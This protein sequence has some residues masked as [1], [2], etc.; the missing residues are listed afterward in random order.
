MRSQQDKVCE[1][2][3]LPVEVVADSQYLRSITGETVQ[4]YYYTVGGVLTVD[5]GQAAGTVVVGKT[6]YGGILTNIG[7]VIGTYLD[8]S[9][10]FTSTALTTEVEYPHLV[11]ESY[12]QQHGH[13]LANA[14]V[15]GLSNGQYCV[16]YR[17]GT[18]YGKK[19]SI[20]TSLAATAYKISSTQANVVLEAGDLEIGAVELKDAGTDTRANVLAANTA[21]TT[22][23]IVLAT[24][25]IGADGTVP[26]TGSLLTNAPFGQITDAST[27]VD[28]LPLTSATVSTGLLSVAGEIKDFDT[29]AGDDPTPVMGVIGASAGGAK[30]LYL[31]PDD[32]AMDATPTILPIGGE[33]RAAATTYTDGDATVLQSDVNGN[34]KTTVSAD[35]PTTLTGGSKTKAAAAGA[36]EAL[37]ASL[38]TKSIY[39]RAKS[40]NTSDVYIGDSTVDANQIVLAAN[41]S[42]TIDIANRATVFV[43]VAVG[44]EGVDYLCMS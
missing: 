10:S 31:V 12:L 17:T 29:G 28:V 33:Y 27:N 1:Q 39:I 32:A 20:T 23:T 2:K 44:G 22:A 38:A 30:P 11:A 14:I 4:L 25:E 5:A 41:D 9:L 6:T 16:D 18:I 42:I 19:T 34:L 35:I 15:Q 40:T 36:G 3:G 7:N 24:Q 37:G 43:D 8:S 13:T 26:P 21:R